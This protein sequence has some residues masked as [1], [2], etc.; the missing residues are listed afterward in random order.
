MR[1]INKTLLLFVIGIGVGLLFALQI[2]T[3]SSRSTN[4]VTPFVALQ[5]TKSILEKDQL[6]LKEKLLELREDISGQQNSIKSTKKSTKTLVE[7]ADK[8]KDA[9][10]L[11]DK[12]G[13]GLIITLA[14]AQEGELTIDSIVHAADLRDVVNLLWQDK[15]QAISI[16]GQRV[17]A[18]TSIDSIVNTILVNNTKIANPFEIKAI[19]DQAKIKQTLLSGDY[20]KDIIRRKNN[21]HLIYNIEPSSEV[22]ISGYDGGFVVKYSTIKE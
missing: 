11:T 12:K 2:Q 16:N 4:P 17:V 9:V 5:D 19:G 10:G 1:K 7:E 14:D 6:D 18:T 15:A 21:N 3:P 13:K 8:L 20:L 22:T